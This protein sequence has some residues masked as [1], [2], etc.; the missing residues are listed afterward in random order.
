MAIL[1]HI[2]DKYTELFHNYNAKLSNNKLIQ[3]EK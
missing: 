3:T 2:Q 1:A